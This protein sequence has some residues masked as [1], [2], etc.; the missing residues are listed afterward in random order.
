MDLRDGPQ[1][2]ELYG[3]ALGPE[4]PIV[5]TPHHLGGRAC[6]SIPPPS[7]SGVGVGPKCSIRVLG[8]RAPD[9]VIESRRPGNLSQPT[10]DSSR[11]CPQAL[12]SK[13]PPSSANAGQRMCTWGIPGAL[14]PHPLSRGSDSMSEMRKLGL[15]CCGHLSRVTQLARVEPGDDPRP[16]AC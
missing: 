5:H 7:N 9:R 3:R 12:Q 1:K 13:C 2:A 14:L 4:G 15:R 10:R 6:W 8:G 11:I 16:Q